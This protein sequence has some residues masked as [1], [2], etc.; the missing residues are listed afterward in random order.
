MSFSN[1]PEL[2]MAKE[3]LLRVLL[4][5]YPS[6]TNPTECYTEAKFSPTPLERILLELCAHGDEEFNPDFDH[7]AN[8]EAFTNYLADKH[9]DGW[10]E[11]R[12]PLSSHREDEEDDEEVVRA[13]KKLRRKRAR[14]YDFVMHTMYYDDDASLIREGMDRLTEYIAKVL[15]SCLTDPDPSKSRQAVVTRLTELDLLE[16]AR[17]WVADHQK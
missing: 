12:N 1:P 16:Y 6:E 17:K 13:L 7:G 4:V 11:G 9:G 14:R 8:M 2:Y 15:A 3:E 10:H 5:W